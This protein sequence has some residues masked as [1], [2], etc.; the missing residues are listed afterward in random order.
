M[1]FYHMSESEID[2]LSLLQLQIKMSKMGEIEKT[3]N[4][5]PKGM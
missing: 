5:T 4:P 3:L 1:V 2:D